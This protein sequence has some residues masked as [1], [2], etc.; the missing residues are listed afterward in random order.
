MCD[1]GWQPRRT[2]IFAHWDAGDLGQLGSYEWVE[3]FVCH[4]FH[5][6]IGFNSNSSPVTEITYTVST[7]TLNS[8]IPYRTPGSVDLALDF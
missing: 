4:S 1:A 5:F 8:T 3:V 7:G 6:Y 2:I